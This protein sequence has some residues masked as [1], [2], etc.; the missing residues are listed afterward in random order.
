AAFRQGRPVVAHGRGGLAHIAVPLLLGGQCLGAL[1]TGQVF[2]QYP[3][4][5]PLDQLARKFGVAPQA[6]WQV[7][8]RE[9]PVKEA[10]LRVYA[11]L[12]MTLGNTFLQTRFNEL[13]E[14]D[15]LAEMTRL[16]DRAVMEISE[17]Q[18]A[19]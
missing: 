9:H 8:R 4:Q 15:R 3:E 1:L 14:A 5:L 6:V 13:Q 2:D 11:D 18:R 19:E 7:A 17:R 12:L 10:V 16:R